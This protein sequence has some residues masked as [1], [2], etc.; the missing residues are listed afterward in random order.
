M[1]RFK[2]GS[3]AAKK[4]APVDQTVNNAATNETTAQESTTPKEEPKKDGKSKKLFATKIKFNIKELKV[5]TPKVKKPDFSKLTEKAKKPVKKAKEKHEINK[6]NR[7]YDYHGVPDEVATCNLDAGVISK[8][9]QQDVMDDYAMPV[10][11]DYCSKLIKH[12]LHNDTFTKR[13]GVIYD[14]VNKFFASDFGTADAECNI[15]DLQR[16]IQSRK[17]AVFGREFADEKLMAGIIRKSYATGKRVKGEDTLQLI[18][19]AVTHAYC[20]GLFLDEKQIF[21]L[22]PK[23]NTEL[24][25]IWNQMISAQADIP[26]FVKNIFTIDQ[27]GS[28]QYVAARTGK[29]CVFGK[30]AMH[31]T[32]DQTFTNTEADVAKVDL[33]NA[34]LDQ[35]Y[36]AAVENDHPVKK[37]EFDGHL[38][39]SPT[40]TPVQK[41]VTFTPN[42]EKNTVNPG[43][44]AMHMAMNNGGSFTTEPVPEVQ[45]E[46]PKQ[47]ESK[48][49]V[50]D[51]AWFEANYQRLD[52]FTN[53][54]SKAGFG[55]KYSFDPVFKGLIKAQI[56][57]K[58]TTGVM[59]TLLIDPLLVYGDTLRIITQTNTDGDLRKELF[60]PISQENVVIKAVKGTLGKGDRKAMME[61]LPRC[62]T[63]FRGDY[64]FL[65]QVDM[66][67]LKTEER[68]GLPFE[69][70]KKL[71]CNISDILKY[72]ETAGLRFHIAEYKDSDNFK[73]VCDGTEVSVFNSKILQDPKYAACVTSGGLSA[74]HFTGA[75][76]VAMIKLL[77]GTAQ[78][79][80]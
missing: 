52:K 50:Q 44:I 12:E 77:S 63:D 25:T 32:D 45:K 16:H 36:K 22:I 17:R 56:L 71:V 49:P 72:E 73:L 40:F 65:D 7:R 42:V 75:D 18:A 74:W 37:K 10:I 53:V 38:H 70:W 23:T 2:K 78:N 28:C 57:D 13:D 3:R 59:N 41:E 34:E 46:E 26:D 24:F 39:T 79:N 48:E 20:T 67:G 76:G 69:D 58:K 61:K 62:L 19:W 29:Y 30:D 47:E 4:E 51:N 6:S 14:L 55:V 68:S 80:S 66:R 11:K 1:V 33:G 15:M 8:Y 5:E 43:N 9:V 35:Q 54:V 27:T 21:D 64:S 60:I 31:P